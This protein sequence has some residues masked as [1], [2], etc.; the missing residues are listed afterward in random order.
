MKEIFPYKLPQLTNSL[1][2][3][4]RTSKSAR[5]TFKTYNGKSLAGKGAHL[6]LISEVCTICEKRVQLTSSSMGIFL[7]TQRSSVLI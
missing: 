2:V 7:E 1:F 4:N 3:P 5:T 6:D